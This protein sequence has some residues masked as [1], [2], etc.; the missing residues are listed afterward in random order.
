M[1][2]THA[3]G[4]LFTICRCCYEGLAQLRGNRRGRNPTP[5]AAIVS[6]R[7]FERLGSMKF[8]IFLLGLFG[9]EG[10]PDALVA[11]QH[12]LEECEDGKGTGLFQ[13]FHQRHVRHQRHFIESEDPL[14]KRVYLVSVSH[15]S[16]TVL[17]RNVMRWIFDSLGATDSCNYGSFPGK[18]TSTV[19]V[20]KYGYPFDCWARPENLRFDPMSR[21]STILTLRRQTADKERFRGVMS[22]RDPF[23]MIVSS[24]CCLSI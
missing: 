2:V 24:Y 19:T 15:K 22:I 20:D 5:R 6:E 7:R 23:E 16:G 11:V 9:T 1:D 14:K 8:F 4:C 10:K 18:I 3:F 17:L 13:K 21:A 12:A